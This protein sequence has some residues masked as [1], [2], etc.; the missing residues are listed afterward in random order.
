MVQVTRDPSL[1]QR[2]VIIAVGSELLTATRLDTNSLA[3]TE[4]LDE[5]GI[6]VRDKLVAGDRRADLASHVRSALERADLVIV[7]G[8]LGPTDD[9]VTREGVSDAFGL[10][11]DEDPAVL[12]VIRQRFASRGLRM[13][14]VNRR[15]AQVPRGALVLPNP[16]G[17]AP[18]LWIEH[19]SKAVALLPGPPREMK[20]MLQ[21]L[22]TTQLA[23]RAGA[24]RLR[25]RVVKVAGRTESRVEELTQPTYSRW[26]TGPQPIETTILATPGQIELHLS[27]RGGD[28]EAADRALGAAVGELEAIL[29]ADVVSIDGRSIEEVVGSLLQARGWH[30]ALAESC[31]GGLVTSRLTDV[32]G[33]SAYVERGV[34]VYSNRAKVELL[35]V[36]GDMIREH[37]AV[38]ESVAAAMAAAVADRAGADVGLAITGIAGPSGATEAKPVGTVCIAV[39]GPSTLV[40]TFRFLGAR[41]LVK[42]FAAFTALDMVRRMLLEAPTEVDWIK[43]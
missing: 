32:P 37:G 18:G 26:L 28:V 2:A 25:R 27:A 35:G 24:I 21:R 16:H 17:S 20:P 12:D 22:A 33:S 3:I 10:E 6:E 41:D 42:S 5:L 14:E 15:Q 23:A 11:M 31:T 39:R 40:R 43:K 30:I 7:T 34:V 19:G 1:P 9:D 36:P 29:R 8:G 38:S 13:P 4:T